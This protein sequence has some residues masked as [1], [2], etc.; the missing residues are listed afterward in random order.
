M[1]PGQEYL[2]LNRAV[3]GVKVQQIL[4]QLETNVEK[5]YLRH[6]QNECSNEKKRKE[7]AQNRAMGFF[8]PDKKM[9]EAAE[10]M[11]TPSCDAIRDKFGS[12]YVS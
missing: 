5:A 10:R 4:T 1:A 3:D 11:T 6:M 9:W 7:M 2:D 8:G 12:Q